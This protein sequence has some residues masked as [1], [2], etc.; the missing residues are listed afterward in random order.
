MVKRGVVNVPVTPVPPP[1]DEMHDVL[2]VDVQLMVDVPPLAMEGVVAVRATTGTACGV[3]ETSADPA[4]S[5]F[6]LTAVT[7]KYQVVPLV[8]PRW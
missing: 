7:T 1:P 2:L 6:L 5:P 4:L 8:R 3:A